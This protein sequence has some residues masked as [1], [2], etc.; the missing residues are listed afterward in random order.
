MLKLS[1][2][3]TVRDRE[4][5]Y[6]G[7]VSLLG[8]ENVH[9]SG[10]NFIMFYWPYETSLDEILIEE[11]IYIKNLSAKYKTK[12]KVYRVAVR[13]PDENDFLLRCLKNIQLDGHV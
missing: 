3:K 4:Y 1:F 13:L 2:D 11:N 5:F 8:D 12:R 6:D 10:A 7:L 9:K